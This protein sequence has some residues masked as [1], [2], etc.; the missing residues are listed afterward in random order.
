MC[1]A[2]FSERMH[3]GPAQFSLVLNHNA[4]VKLQEALHH[5]AL[6]KAQTNLFKNFIVS[7][8]ALRIDAYNYAQDILLRESEKNEWI[9]D[10]VK[11]RWVKKKKKLTEYHKFCSKKRKEGLGF[12]EISELWKEHKK[13]GQQ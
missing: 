6:R 5:D 9:Y 8:S 11:G 1:V 3:G 10:Y 2:D 12:S 4:L 13:S 7:L